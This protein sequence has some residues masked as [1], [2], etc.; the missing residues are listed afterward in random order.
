MWIAVEEPVAVEA[1]E[2]KAIDDLPEAI[3]LGLREV[4]GVGERLALDVL[5]DKHGVGAEL[6]VDPGNAD[7]RVALE[8]VV[9]ALLPARLGPVVELAADAFLQVANDGT[10]VEAA[11]DEGGEADQKADV[12][13]V[14]LDRLADAGVLDLDSDLCPI[15]KGGAVDLAD[16]G[17]REGTAF[18]MLEDVP[19]RTAICALE[20]LLDELVGH[21]RRVRLERSE[22][23]SHLV[24][25]DARHEREDLADLHHGALHV[26]HRASDVLGGAQ[27]SLFAASL[28]ALGVQGQVSVSPP[29]GSG[30]RE[31]RG[32]PRTSKPATPD[33][34]APPILRPGES[35]DSVRRTAAAFVAPR[36]VMPEPDVQARLGLGGDSS[37]SDL[38]LTATIQS[39]RWI[40]GRRK[41]GCEQST[42]QRYRRSCGSTRTSR[43][44]GRVAVL[45]SAF[46]PPTIAHLHLLE[47]ALRV[48]GVTLAAAMLSTRN[49]A[50]GVVGAGLADR[51]GMLLAAIGRGRLAGR[52]GSQRG[53]AG[54]S[55]G[56]AAPG[57][58]LAPTSISSSGSTR[59]CGCSTRC[60]TTTWSGNSSRSSRTTA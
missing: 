6:V 51:V 34:A 3:A 33:G 47:Q 7:E 52:A 38:R 30:A 54:R 25:E 14:V 55:G 35:M 10:G 24:R 58:S 23:T 42:P 11:G 19:R 49:V 44:P 59:S 13:E 45:P 56:G 46:N 39:P 40:P 53:A 50:K 31:P 16:R 37:R 9:E 43:S 8:G 20:D 21:R 22:L 12:G 41:I 36:I 57:R 32:S 29:Q 27:D 18:E 15:V 17:G 60:T 26:A 28:S 2:A 4:A 48:E 1:A 5:L